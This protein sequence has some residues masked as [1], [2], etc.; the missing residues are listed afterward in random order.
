MYSCIAIRP[1]T[2]KLKRKHEMGDTECT[3]FDDLLL[4]KL[5]ICFAVFTAPS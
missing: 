2:L 5:H 1:F 3:I 4:P